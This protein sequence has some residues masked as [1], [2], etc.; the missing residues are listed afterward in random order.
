MLK[1]PFLELDQKIEGSVYTDS[2]HKAIYATDAS[3]YRVLPQAV[4]YPKNHEDISIVL[5]WANQ[6][7][8]PIIPRSAG[9]SLAGQCVGEGLILDVSKF[10]NKILEVNPKKGTAILQP[11]VVRDS[12]NAQIKETG[13]FFGPNTSTSNRCTIGGMIANN[14]SGSTSIQYGCSR[15]KILSAKVVLS[16][17]SSALVKKD[18]I[19]TDSPRGKEISIALSA[20]LSDEDLTLIQEK[21]PPPQ[22]RRRNSGYALEHLFPPVN[23]F[24]KLL[25]GSEGTLAILTE[26][27]VQLDP[28]P[29]SEACLICPHFHTI[30]AALNAVKP[31]MDH[32][33][34]ACELM[35]KTILDCTRENQNFE[36]N[37]FFL[38]QDPE[39]VLILELRAKSQDQLSKKIKLLKETIHQSSLAYSAPIIEKKDMKKVWDLRKAGLG[40]LANLR[41]TGKAVACIE[42]TAV[43]LEDLSAYIKEFTDIM[44]GFG[45]KAVYYAHAGAGELHLRPILDLKTQEGKKHFRAISKEVALLVKKYKGS[46]SGE[47]GDGR[48]RSEFL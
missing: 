23:S 11:G 6:N 16:D 20:L 21:L 43:A 18:K 38:D 10:M 12:F 14:S 7:N 30:E 33:L 22:V 29:P 48:V 41:G 9:T 19:I 17:G 32:E 37:R 13:L 3:V 15:D 5:K 8:I 24:E 35:D 2:L 44:R 34:Y 31:L 46:L 27:E 25:A 28:Q 47:H 4:C 40:L 45:Q 26:I 42:D 1:S 39:A 36:Q